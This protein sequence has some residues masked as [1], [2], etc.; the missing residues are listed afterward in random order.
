M[1]VQSKP[2]GGVVVPTDAGIAGLVQL[3]T[4]HARDRLA[5]D[6]YSHPYH[7]DVAIG[8]DFLIVLSLENF[9]GVVK[10]YD[11]KQRNL[12]LLVHIDTPAVLETFDHARAYPGVEVLTLRRA[13]PDDSGPDVTLELNL[14]G[15]VLDRLNTRPGA[16][17]C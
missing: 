15:K 16:I 2:R 9:Q 4:A 11:T 7:I 3:L 17:P 6:Y 12:P 14:V 1:S 13:A 10:Y 8:Y 5:F